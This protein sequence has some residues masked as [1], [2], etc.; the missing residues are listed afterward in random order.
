M[1]RSRGDL[2][3]LCSYVCIKPPSVVTQRQTRTTFILVWRHAQTYV[4][5]R[6]VRSLCICP[7]VGRVSSTARGMSQLVVSLSDQT[8]WSRTETWQSRSRAVDET[9]RDRISEDTLSS[10]PFFLSSLSFLSPPLHFSSI[11]PFSLTSALLPSLP[12]AL[13]LFVPAKLMPGTEICCGHL[14]LKKRLI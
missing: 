2:S 10:P 9:W 12:L 4:D 1:F 11:H 8:G 14:S 3:T 5:S 6:L 7:R 13:V